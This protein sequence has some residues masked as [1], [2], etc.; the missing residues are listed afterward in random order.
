[1][2]MFGIKTVVTHLEPL[3]RER[4]HFKVEEVFMYLWLEMKLF[5]VLVS[6]VYM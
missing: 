3:S 2:D 5:K 4:I 6:T 1:M